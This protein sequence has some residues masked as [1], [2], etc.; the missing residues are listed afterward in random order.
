MIA[1]LEVGANDDGDIILESAHESDHIKVRV[2]RSDLA[3]H[4][5]LLRL[6]EHAIPHVLSQSTPS[7]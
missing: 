2:A 1:D 3:Q 7:D 4:L 6:R 5:G